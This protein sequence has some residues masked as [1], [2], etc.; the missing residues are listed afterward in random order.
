MNNKNIQV[1]KKEDKKRTTISL[2][3]K[4]YLGVKR[5][6]YFGD[7]FDDIIG[8]LLENNNELLES[9]CPE[10]PGDQTLVSSTTPTF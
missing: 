1:E 10:R 6:G 7:S 3:Y 8:R 2:S 9:D 5:M 4:N